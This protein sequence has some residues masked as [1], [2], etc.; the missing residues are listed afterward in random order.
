MNVLDHA[1]ATLDGSARS[2]AEG[3]FFRIPLHGNREFGAVAV[4]D[5]A[6]LPLD[7]L[8]RAKNNAKSLLGEVLQQRLEYE[9]NQAIGRGAHQ[10]ATGIA[11][12]THA[13]ARAL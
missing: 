9:V 4:L 10:V 6:P 12:L 11:L 3:R 13:E 2:N 7:H 5:R 8:D 1:L